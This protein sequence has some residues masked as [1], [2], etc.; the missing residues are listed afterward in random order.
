MAAALV[1]SEAPDFEMEILGGEKKTLK[2]FLAEG[3]PIV[4]DFYANF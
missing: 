2:D 3:K 4:I 1:G